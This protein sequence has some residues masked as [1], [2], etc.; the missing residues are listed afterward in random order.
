MLGR[1]LSRQAISN[2]ITLDIAL[3]APGLYQLAVHTEDGR[4]FWG[5]LEKL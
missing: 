5:K 3:L 2:G 4:V 1:E